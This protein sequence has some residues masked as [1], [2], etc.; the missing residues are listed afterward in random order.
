[1]SVNWLTVN[2]AS[3]SVHWPPAADS[4]PAVRGSSTWRQPMD[5]TIAAIVIPAAPPPATTRP[6]RGSTPSLMVISRIAS[7]MC[8]P[9]TTST[10]WAASATL[11]PSRAASRSSTARAAAWSSRIRP[12]RN[13]PGSR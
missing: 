10:A 12:P 1:M 2:S 9:A 13:A 7:A 11:M 3:T 8:S 6:S 5:S 4:A